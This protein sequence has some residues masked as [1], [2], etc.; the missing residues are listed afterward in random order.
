[1]AGARATCATSPSLK[2]IRYYEDTGLI[3]KAHR[4]A[5]GYRAYS[6]LHM[7]ELSF[8]ERA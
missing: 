2:T 3:R 4:Q 1:M 8:I 6:E 7:R 5:N